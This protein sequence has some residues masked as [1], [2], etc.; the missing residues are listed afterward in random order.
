MGRKIL[1]GFLGLLAV[2]ALIARIR[3]GQ[4]NAEIRHRI[5]D[6]DEQLTAAPY[7]APPVRIGYVTVRVPANFAV[8][9]PELATALDAELISPWFA[10]DLA[11]GRLV[12]VGR[13]HG[14]P[15]HTR[16]TITVRPMEDR[17][18]PAIVDAAFCTT[19]GESISRRL[20]VPIVSADVVPIGQG[21]SCR[22]E[23]AGTGPHDVNVH[24]LVVL[25][26]SSAFVACVI[27][28]GARLV[29]ACSDVANSVALAPT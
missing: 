29:S 16:H 8:V 2:A 19:Q 21:T 17:L 4:A 3:N 5:R 15:G 24:W 26:D 6:V 25:P 27:N 20:G 22:V 18:D 11:E 9:T 28:T 14:S 12:L 13:L 23:T 7:H 1:G 10:P